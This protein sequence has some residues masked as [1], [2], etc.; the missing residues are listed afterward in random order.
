[1]SVSD[2]LVAGA[3]VWKAP[4]GTA[5]PDETTVAA[6]AAWGGTWEQIGY[7]AAP[8]SVKVEKEQLD[9]MIQQ[10]I[11]VVG[12]VNT[13]E[14]WS[15]E[16]TLAEY[17]MDH[18][19]LALG[20]IVGTTPAG[21][22][23]VGYDQYDAGGDTTLDRISFG[24]EGTYVSAAGN[25]HPV[26][27]VVWIA[28]AEAGAELEFGKETQTGIPLKIK[29]IQDLSKAAGKQ[30]VSGYKVTAPASS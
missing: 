3:T 4:V 9:L 19:A 30:Y 22:G 10:A 8:L 2:I 13:K 27:L 26:R 23:Q 5:L 6:G 20:G 15:L 25:T 28:T 14:N 29:A 1:M 18:L 7:T 21:A 12:R 16:T 24:F 11:G 17:A